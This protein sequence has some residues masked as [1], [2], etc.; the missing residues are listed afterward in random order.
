VKNVSEI[1]IAA[2]TTANVL[3]LFSKMP[4]LD[5]ELSA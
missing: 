3:R 4:P 5:A 1:E 2:A